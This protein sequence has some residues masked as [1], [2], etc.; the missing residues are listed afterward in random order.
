M[1]KRGQEPL[2]IAKNYDSYV[3]TKKRDSH[4]LVTNSYPFSAFLPQSH[5]LLIVFLTFESPTGLLL[6]VIF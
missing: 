5:Q 4:L 3:W 2:R 1:F 6:S